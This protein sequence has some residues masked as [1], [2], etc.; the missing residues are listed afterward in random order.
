MKRITR[1]RLLTDEEAAEYKEV[2]EKVEKEFPPAPPTYPARPMN[3]GN[4]F[5]AWAS[6][7]E[8]DPEDWRYRPK[9]NG[10]RVLLHLP[11]MRTWNRQLEENNWVFPA[12]KKLKDIIEESDIWP[13]VLQWLDLELLY[14]KTSVAKRSI[15]VLDYVSQEPWWDRMMN[16]QT[17]FSDHKLDGLARPLDNEVYFAPPMSKISAEIVI[18]W[19]EM[20][21]LNQDWGATFFEGLVA[22]ELK[23]AY[24]VQ[25]FSP[26]KETRHWMKYRFVK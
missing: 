5:Q 8:L 13:P 19:E 15:I 23:A 25:L 4:L 12:F 1:N 7:Q 6:G 16:L 9:Y 22:Y 2:R 11:T 17:V 24:P 20:A 14:G 3:G 18:A 21:L 26:T 10:R